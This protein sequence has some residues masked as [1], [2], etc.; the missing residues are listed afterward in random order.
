M[1]RKI[2]ALIL[3]AAI[4]T[5]AAPAFAANTERI[6]PEYEFDENLI[7][8]HTVSNA[9]V[10]SDAAELSEAEEFLVRFEILTGYEDGTLR[11][12]NTITRAEAAAMLV[13]IACT[14]ESVESIE[15]TYDKDGI[16]ELQKEAG[17]SGM[18]W[19]YE[20]FTD[21]EL[22]SWYHPY[23]YYSK[24][25]DWINGYEDGSFRPENRV[26]EI[27]FVCMLEKLLGYSERIEAEGGWQDGVL[28][29]NELLDIADNP[30]DE[31]L[32]RARMC[33]T[34]FNT[35]NANI[36]VQMGTS[37]NA[38]SDTVENEFSEGPT[39][40]NR[41]GQFKLHGTITEVSDKTVVFVP[42]EDYDLDSEYKL[43]AGT[44]YTFLKGYS[45]ITAGEFDVYVD[46]DND[47]LV[48]TL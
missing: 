39:L 21:V 33:E 2:T 41:K 43:N 46:L 20:G 36:V 30:T 11:L 12:E 5:A 26:T 37:Y 48:F 32:T 1:K 27:E 24:R 44:E 4:F 17:I 18:E 10:F 19:E 42:A 34:A 38:A 15:T 6:T 25:I 3:A 23:V 7:K 29:V 22:D 31:P 40:M 47:T 9:S 14:K 35:L 16:A 8:A 45:D 13:R 28:A